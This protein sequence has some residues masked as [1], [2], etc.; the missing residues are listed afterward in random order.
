METKHRIRLFPTSRSVNI[1]S[2]TVLVVIITNITYIEYISAFNLTE[3]VASTHMNKK[4][5][6]QIFVDPRSSCDPGMAM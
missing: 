2:N 6:V 1:Q 4:K 5:K 3:I